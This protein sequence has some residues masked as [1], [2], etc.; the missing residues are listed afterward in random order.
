MKVIIIGAGGHGRV[1]LDALLAG[2]EH[3]VIGLLDDREGLIG[4]KIRGVPVIGNIKSI[5]T[6]MYKADKDI[7]I[8]IGIGD[9]QC[10]TRIY[11]LVRDKGFNLINALHPAAVI[12]PEIRLGR[13][14][15]ALANSVINCGSIVEDN[16]IINTSASV[17]HDCHIGKHAHIAPGVHL[18]GN[19]SVGEGS[20]LGVGTVVIPGVNIG[21]WAIAAAGAV[22]IRDVPDNILVKGVPAAPEDRS[23]FADK[24]S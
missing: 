7:G 16:V 22:V 20:F 19:V 1:V 6:D 8:V 18:A 2:Q 12:S 10:R 23:L 3:R 15:V 11:S 5:D 14:I 9:N 13:G 4:Q 17:D 24:E 21:K